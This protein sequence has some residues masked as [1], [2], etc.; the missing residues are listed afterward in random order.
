MASQVEKVTI[1]LPQE[2]I[3]FTDEIARERRTSRSKVVS[4]CLRELADKRLREQME[5]GYKAM[6][7]ENRRFAEVAGKL[8]EEVLP[9]WE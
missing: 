4:S 1:S 2:L 5:E 9:E 8:A 7:K 3:R 6:A